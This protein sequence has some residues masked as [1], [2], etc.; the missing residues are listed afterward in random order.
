M[1]YTISTKVLDQTH[2]IYVLK[3]IRPNFFNF[4]LFMWFFIFYSHKTKTKKVRSK[5]KQCIQINAKCMIM[6]HLMHEESYRDRKNQIKDQ[7]SKSSTI[8]TF[9]HPNGTIV[10]NECLMR[11]ETRAGRIRTGDAHQQGGKNIKDFFHKLTIFPQNRFSFHSTPS[12]QLKFLFSFYS[13]KSLKL[14]A[15]R[16]QMTKGT[17]MVTNNGFRSTRLLRE[18]SSI[19]V[20]FFLQHGTLR[21]Y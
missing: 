9:L 8:G 14:K 21:S 13:F 5:Q 15:M 7:K 6:K 12:K 19:M 16:S 17:I 4:S 3:H 2:M 20:L 1:H 18:G 11:S 10:W